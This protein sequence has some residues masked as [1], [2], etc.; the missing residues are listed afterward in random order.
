MNEDRKLALMEEIAER[1]VI[2]QS[3]HETP[4]ERKQ[5]LL[6]EIV[7]LGRRAV[8]GG[9]PRDDWETHELNW[10]AYCADLRTNFMREIA[11]A[12]IEF[13]R[14]ALTAADR[15]D[16]TSESEQVLSW[17]QFEG[18]REKLLSELPLED[19]QALESAERD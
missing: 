19:R 9:V 13:E 7:E 11:W 3:D 8:G 12:I 17:W 2:L 18:G 6:D 16:L 5:H 15:G 4:I 1:S 14:T 10:A